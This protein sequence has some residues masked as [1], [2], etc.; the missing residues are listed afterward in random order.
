MIGSNPSS[1]KRAAKPHELRLGQ[2]RLI[3]L[4]VPL[5]HDAPGEMVKPKIEYISHG[6]GGLKGMMDT[7][8]A[9]PKDFVY[10]HGCGWAVENLGVG[11]HTG[12][13]IDAPYHYGATSEGKPARRIDAVAL[14]WCF[15]AGIVLDM[16]H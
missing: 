16:R 1:P 15:G 13:H 8:G 9:Q 11:S 2:L 6:A 12:T 5:E 10:S 7:F 4:S 3:D 14:E